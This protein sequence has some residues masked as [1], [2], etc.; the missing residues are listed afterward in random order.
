MKHA[1]ITIQRAS[2]T[3]D[4]PT[5]YALKKWIRHACAHPML[6]TLRLV[7]QP[8]GHRLNAAFRQQHH[9]TNVLSFPYETHPRVI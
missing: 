4:Q 9:P 7:D 8:E 6:V 3:T 5:D 1:A 2:R